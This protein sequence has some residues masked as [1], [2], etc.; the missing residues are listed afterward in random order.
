MTDTQRDEQDYL[1]YIHC[2]E[3]WALVDSVMVDKTP[4]GVV[5]INIDSTHPDYVISNF[6]DGPKKVLLPNHGTEVIGMLQQLQTTNNKIG[7][8]SPGGNYSSINAIVKEKE[9]SN[10]F[11]IVNVGI[12][13]SSQR[14]IDHSCKQYA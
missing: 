7:I 5:D 11:E 6:I 13:S 8:A 2:P 4:V 1:D 9:K 10:Q 3:A 12:Q 14:H